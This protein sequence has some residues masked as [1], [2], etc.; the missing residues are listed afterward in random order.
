MLLVGLTGGIACGKSTVSLLLKESHHIVVVDSDLV[1][2]ELQRPFMPCTRKIARRW[3]NCVDP[4]SGEVNRAALGSIIFSDPSARR[5][6]A[7]IMNFPIFRATMKMVIGLWWQSLRQQLRGQGPLLVVLDVPLLYESN[8][9]TW[10]VD[11]V[12]VVSCSEEQQVE[13]MA[14][15]NGLTREQALQRINAQMPIS[16]KCKRADRVIHNEE[17]LSELEHSVADTVAWMQ[18]QSGGR[19]AFALSGALAVGVSLGAVVVYCCLRIVF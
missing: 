4:Q 17:S 2:R 1:V 13:R 9:Y 14:K 19:V 12:V 8:I 5:A 7:R 16:E 6:L 3:P 10:L 18:Q 15:R 11:R